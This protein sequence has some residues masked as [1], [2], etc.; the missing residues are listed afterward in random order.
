MSMPVA[1]PINRGFSVMVDEADVSRLLTRTWHAEERPNGRVYARSGHPAP[2]VYMHRFILD[3]PR[4]LDVDHIDRNGLNNCRSN[5]RLCTR[6]HNNGNRIV[7][8]RSLLGLKGVSTNRNG[9]FFARI[10]FRDRQYYLGTYRT[11][12]EAAQAYDTAAIKFH[13]QF[14]RLNFPQEG[15]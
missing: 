14:A 2:S 4:G 1:F 7:E 12:E 11:Q 8:K 9:T 3:A 10:Y 15:R 13:G 5:L 6:T